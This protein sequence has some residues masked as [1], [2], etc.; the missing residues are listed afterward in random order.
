MWSTQWHLKRD[1]KVSP[2]LRAFVGFVRFV[3]FVDER[4]FWKEL[5]ASTHIKKPDCTY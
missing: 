2:S 4:K 3:R 1:R 5:E